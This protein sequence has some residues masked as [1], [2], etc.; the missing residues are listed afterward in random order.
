M[1]ACGPGKY[2]GLLIVGAA[3]TDGGAPTAPLCGVGFFPTQQRTLVAPPHYTT[4]SRVPAEWQA[5]SSGNSPG[6]Q[7]TNIK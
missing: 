5:E 7:K 4:F 2:R 6:P 3:A 1:R